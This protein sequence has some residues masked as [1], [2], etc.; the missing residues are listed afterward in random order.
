MRFNFDSGVRNLLL[1]SNSGCFARQW[2]VRQSKKENCIWNLGFSGSENKFNPGAYISSKGSKKVELEL[3]IPHVCFFF[4]GDDQMVNVRKVKQVFSKLKN[5]K[6]CC[7]I[8]LYL[9]MFAFSW[10]CICVICDNTVSS[11]NFLN[12]FYK[13]KNC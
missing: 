4:P 6:Y 1:N 9:S 5:C 8:A 10:L 2:S 13:K 3:M 7:Y 12:K 11:L